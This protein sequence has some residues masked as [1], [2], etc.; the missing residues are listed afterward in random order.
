MSLSKFSKVS[1]SS[2][3]DSD[4]ELLLSQV[5]RKRARRRLFRETTLIKPSDKSVNFSS[6]ATVV[7]MMKSTCI[8]AFN[9]YLIT[10]CIAL[11]T[12]Q[13][14]IQLVLYESAGREQGNTI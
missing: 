11:L 12:V 8:L 3:D 7:R 10:S 14:C 1:E 9:N 5:K 2:S 13:V 4:L 6:T